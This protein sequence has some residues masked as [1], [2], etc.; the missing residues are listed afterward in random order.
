[1]TNRVTYSPEDFKKMCR[2]ADRE[3]ESRKLVVLLERVKRQIAAHENAGA[4]VE[5]PKPP[6]GTLS[7]NSGLTLI[8]SRLAPF[9]R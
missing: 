3:H 9:E 5:L 6:S 8:P 4:N 1:M 7:G 2:Q